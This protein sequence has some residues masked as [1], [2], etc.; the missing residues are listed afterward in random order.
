LA[1]KN[2]PEKGEMKKMSEFALGITSPSPPKKN[3][4]QYLGV[5]ENN[6]AEIC[7]T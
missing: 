7:L 4:E 1:Q 3:L 5:Y 2:E 6:A